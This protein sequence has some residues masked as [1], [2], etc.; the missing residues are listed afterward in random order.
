[1]DPEFDPAGG[2]ETVR[3]ICTLSR[4]DLVAGVV[5]CCCTLA[6]CGGLGSVGLRN[7]GRF[8]GR[9]GRECYESGDRIGC[10]NDLEYLD[11]P[12]NCELIRI[13]SF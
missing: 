8:P 9:I 6:R 3:S 1:M 13:S 4:S 11:F 10:H 2:R 5:D 12:C 7:V